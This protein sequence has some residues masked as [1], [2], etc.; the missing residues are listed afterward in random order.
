LPT[1]VIPAR[2]C[3]LEEFTSEKSTVP[4]ALFRSAAKP[5]P[6]RRFEEEPSTLLSDD[7]PPTFSIS[8]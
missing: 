4:F 8:I 3:R 2:R 7:A 1:R 6:A 5:G